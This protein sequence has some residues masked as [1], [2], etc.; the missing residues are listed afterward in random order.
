MWSEMMHQHLQ[1]QAQQ[2]QQHPVFMAM[3][4][5]QMNNPPPQ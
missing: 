1:F 5:Q 2:A 3:F 4:Q